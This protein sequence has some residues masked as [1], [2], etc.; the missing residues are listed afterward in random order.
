MRKGFLFVYSP[1]WFSVTWPKV[2]S[3]WWNSEKTNLALQSGITYTE[4]LLT[5]TFPE[6]V[7]PCR[8]Q[9]LQ[10]PLAGNFPTQSALT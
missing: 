4:D 3:H 7:I 5:N 9:T 10:Q 8:K 6:D 2:Q 1:K